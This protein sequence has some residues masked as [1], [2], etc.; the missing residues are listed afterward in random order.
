MTNETT[1]QLTFFDNLEQLIPNHQ[2]TQ[3]HD[4]GSSADPK[5]GDEIISEQSELMTLVMERGHI[6]WPNEK[7]RQ[8]TIHRIARFDAYDDHSQLPMADI[9]ALHIYNWLDAERARPLTKEGD[10]SHPKFLSQTSINRYASAV[11]AALSFAVKSRLLDSSPKLN[12]TVEYSRDRYMEDRE[13]EALISHF[14]ERGDQ[15]M[16]DL[17]Y[18]AANTGMRLGEILSLGIVRC[19]KSSHWGEAQVNNDSVYLP[20]KITKTNEGRHVSINSDVREA[21]L[22]L[23]KSLGQHFTHRKF[24]DRWDDARAKIAPGDDNFVFHCLRH[25]C[26]SRMAN[27]LKMNTIVIGRQLGHKSP[28]TTAKYVHEKP[29][30]MQEF[31]S[32][33]RLGGNA[34]SGAS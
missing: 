34:M 7:T 5:S 29:D 18:V 13:I 4:S 14:L 8:N 22:R 30:T 23:T 12:Y 1:N 16:A 11:S 3:K 15:W 21:C 28:D 33:M 20:G 9:T 17:T 2:L 24:Y 27:E 31:S 32:S 25:T 19:G 10:K 26:A 6:I